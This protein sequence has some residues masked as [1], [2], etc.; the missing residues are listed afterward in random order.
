[1]GG[2]IENNTFVQVNTHKDLGIKMEKEIHYESP[3][4]RCQDLS[5]T[6]N[7]SAIHDDNINN[8]DSDEPDY[9]VEGVNEN[10]NSYI[11]I[12]ESQDNRM[13]VE[14]VVISL[15]ND[16]VKCQ[17][18]DKLFKDTSYDDL[19]DHRNENYIIQYKEAD[20]VS[21]YSNDIHKENTNIDAVDTMHQ[22][23]NFIKNEVKDD[24]ENKF[25]I[26]KLKCDINSNDHSSC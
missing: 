9:C 3:Q 14:N 26:T 2:G 13:V 6:T 23:N 12:D 18:P 22:D 11:K 20:E 19:N 24:I 16:I 17:L 4:K 1:M 8:E 5:K 25:D 21:E 10:N 7:N 15:V